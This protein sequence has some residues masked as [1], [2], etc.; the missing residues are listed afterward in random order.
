MTAAA[1]AYDTPAYRDAYGRINAMVIVGEGLACRHFRLLAEAFPEQA[2]E[3]RRLAAMEAGHAREFVG[4]GVHLGIQPE[5]PLARSLFV[6]LHALF[7]EARAQADRV[8]PVVIQCL[9]VECFAVAAYR[10]YLP[11]ADAYAQ[12][13]TA[14]EMADEDEQLDF[15]ERWL[16]PQIGAV[17]CAVTAWCTRTVPLILGIL[18]PLRADV[19]AMGMDPGTLVGEFSALLSESLGRIGFSPEQSR[20]LLAAG[21]A[22]WLAGSAA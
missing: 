21:A 12:P 1:L 9:I 10:A 14:R 22:P 7:L 19:S 2:G 3:L 4:C 18:S 17:G 6:P 20:R 11:V 15:S 5:L 8:G 16:Q 13:I